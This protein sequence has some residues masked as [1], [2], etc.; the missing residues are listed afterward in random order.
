MESEYYKAIEALKS[1]TALSKKEKRNEREE[2]VSRDSDKSTNNVIST[3]REKR[4]E[5]KETY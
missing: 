4:I 2:N 1:K 5:I 3:V